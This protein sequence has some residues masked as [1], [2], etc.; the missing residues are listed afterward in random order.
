VYTV[1]EKLIAGI[2]DILESAILVT[3]L[4]GDI[5]Y[6]NSSA[7]TLL[8]FNAI[9]QQKVNIDELIRLNDG[10]VVERLKKLW[11]ENNREVK[12]ISPAWSKSGYRVFDARLAS[13]DMVDSNP[14]FCVILKDAS[15]KMEINRY[16]AS[17]TSMRAIAVLAGDFMHDMKNIILGVS[18]YAVMAMETVGKDHPVYGDLVEIAGSMEEIATMIERLSL[19]GKKIA[20]K[21]SCERPSDIVR[22]VVRRVSYSIGPDVQI[23][24]IDNNRDDLKIR[25]NRELVVEAFF[26]MLYRVACSIDKGNVDIEIKSCLTGEILE[27]IPDGDIGSEYLCITITDPSRIITR[28]DIEGA[29]GSFYTLK[30]NTEQS[31]LIMTVAISIVRIMDGM[32]LLKE[33]SEIQS[34]HIAFPVAD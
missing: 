18:G 8:D 4:S 7:Q 20:L 21:V 19:I 17:H 6:S 10:K 22:D 28:E 27:N 29:S 12:D 31:S 16:H 9:E 34:I 30:G 13:L 1:E 14:L 11:E 25:V 15:R 3:D 23:N 26:K 24:I 33:N 2:A 32:V 5:I